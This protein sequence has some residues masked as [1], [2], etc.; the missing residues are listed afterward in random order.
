MLI[1]HDRELLFSCPGQLNFSISE[2]RELTI[3]QKDEE[4]WCDHDQ[5]EAKDDLIVPHL[6]ITDKF[7]ISNH[8][9]EG[10]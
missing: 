8:D 3:D 5:Q 7:R 9:N 1:K 4:T 10:K 6:T 2:F